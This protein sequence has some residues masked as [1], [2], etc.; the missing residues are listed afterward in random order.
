[1][2][3]IHFIGTVVPTSVRVTLARNPYVEWKS[4]SGELTGKTELQITDSNVNVIMDLN[5]FDVQND[6]RQAINHAQD[7]ADTTMNVIALQTGNAFSVGLDKI[8]LPDGKIADT[9]CKELEF[10]KQMTALAQQSDF[11]QVVLIA[12]SDHSL[13]LALRDLTD[14]LR[15]AYIGTIGAARAV[16]SIRN[17]FIPEGRERKHG[18]ELMRTALNVTKPYI[19]SITHLSRGPRHADWSGG[20][21]EVEGRKTTERAWVLMNRFLEYRKGG[22]QPLPL[23]DF[24]LLDLT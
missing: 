1:M 16:E 10:P 23:S 19:E 2:T 15:Q 21:D 20:G 14:A 12:L 4:A 18:W 22:D 9:H 5:K 6:L 8:I 11:E 17:Y 3:R 24:P 7:V 13:R